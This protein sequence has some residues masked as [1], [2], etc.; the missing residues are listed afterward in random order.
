MACVN[1]RECIHPNIFTAWSLN[2]NVKTSFDV[3][4]YNHIVKGF[5]MGLIS[6]TKG[7][8]KWDIYCVEKPSIY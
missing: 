8:D 3:D 6:T 5:I 4:L 2:V 1:K 7:N